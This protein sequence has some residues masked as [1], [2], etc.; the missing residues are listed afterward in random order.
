MGGP[1]SLCQAA[2]VRVGSAVVGRGC[3]GL[4]SP[5]LSSLAS[6]PQRRAGEAH[7]CGWV[8]GLGQAPSL[9]F[10]SSLSSVPGLSASPKPLTHVTSRGRQSPLPTDSLLGASP[11]RLGHLREIQAIP[12]R[13]DSP[14]LSFPLKNLM[15]ANNLLPRE[16]HLPDIQVY[17]PN[18]GAL[19]SQGPQRPVRI[20]GCVC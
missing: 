14:S 15:K 4:P 7:G 6:I 8:A 13:S 12:R 16:M 18:H 17:L 2:G 9:L 5:S 1:S 3:P 19:D 20:E 10:T 11:P